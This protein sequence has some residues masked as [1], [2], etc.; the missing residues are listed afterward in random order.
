LLTFKDKFCVWVPM[1]AGDI[2]CVRRDYQYCQQCTIILDPG[3]CMT[4]V[5]N[6][7]VQNFINGVTLE[8]V[9]V[10]CLHIQLAYWPDYNH[11][12]LRQTCQFI[13]CIANVKSI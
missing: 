11:P 1:I 12:C 5:T 2:G 9:Y 7:F 8:P 13:V 4:Y 10:R 6:Q 3:L